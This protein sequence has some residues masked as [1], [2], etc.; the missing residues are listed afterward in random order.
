M[1]T[2]LLTTLPDSTKVFLECTMYLCFKKLTTW[3]PSRGYL[4]HLLLSSE[5]TVWKLGSSD[6]LTEIIMIY[7]HSCLRGTF[8]ILVSFPSTI[9]IKIKLRG[10]KQYRLFIQ[11]KGFNFPLI[12]HPPPPPDRTPLTWH[13]FIRVHPFITSSFM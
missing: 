6:G 10:S 12:E 9:H 13:T 4:Y 2:T 3:R 7:L 5:L 11:K 8:A 1:R